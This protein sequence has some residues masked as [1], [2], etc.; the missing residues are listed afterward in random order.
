VGE[1][2]RFC[3]GF[4]RRRGAERGFFVVNLWWIA[5]KSWFVDGHF[6]V[7]EIFH[8]LLIYFRGFPF[9]EWWDPDGLE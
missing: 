4:W 6:W 1:F 9:W 7:L 2:G 3:W 5:G 8:D